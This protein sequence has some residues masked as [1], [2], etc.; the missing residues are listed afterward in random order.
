VA[1]GATNA[2][3]KNCTVTNI[4]YLAG[5]TTGIDVENS[6]VTTTVATLNTVTKAAYKNSTIDG[7]YY[8]FATGTRTYTEAIAFGGYFLWVDATGVLRIKSGAP[9]SDT[10]GTVVGTQT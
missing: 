10:D 3:L 7:Q 2:Q 1:L 9:T 4:G 5:F 6:T 8:A